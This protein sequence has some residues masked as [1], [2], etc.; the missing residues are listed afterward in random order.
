MPDK[1]YGNRSD[2]A[3]KRAV[4][5]KTARVA[6]LMIF[7]RFIS[8]FI[9]GIAFILIARILG[10]G[11]YGIYTLAAA[12]ASLVVSIGIGDLGVSTAFNKFIGQY[13]GK[14]N[15]AQINKVLSNG[16]AAVLISGSVLTII[17]FLLSGLVAGRLLGS[18]SLSYILEIVSFAILLSTL[19]GTSYNA[20]VGFGKG[21]YVAT[22]IVMH[23]AI[24]STI[25]VTLA[26]LGYGARPP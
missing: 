13:S 8:L 15:N 16:Y 12:Y 14:S 25:S 2:D 9:S 26:L 1:T 18:S 24:Q 4:G 6:S 23:S 22:V 11:T 3:A 20:L 17:A 5:S 21:S 7:G 10:P 19:Y